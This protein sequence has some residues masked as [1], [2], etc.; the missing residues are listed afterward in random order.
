MHKEQRAV[1]TDDVGRE[2]CCAGRQPTSG[3]NPGKRMPCSLK[4][5][6]NGKTQLVDGTG[7]RTLQRCSSGARQKERCSSDTE[8]RAKPCSSGHTQHSWVLSPTGRGSAQGKHVSWVAWRC[9]PL[10]AAEETLQGLS[11][12]RGLEQVD[13]CS[14]TL[15]LL[16]CT[17]LSVGG[18]STCTC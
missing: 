10:P 12:T 8:G 11:L 17:C 6:R 9:L 13:C 14:P 3:W 1:R 16:Q 15:R 18:V 2:S 4:F 7:P 5:T